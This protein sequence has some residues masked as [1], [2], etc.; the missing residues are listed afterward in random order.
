MFAF[1]NAPMQT[2]RQEGLLI[3]QQE[4][5]MQAT[6]F[7][8]E[9]HMWEDADNL[10]GVCFY[11][12]ELFEQTTIVQMMAHFKA[13]LEQLI[14]NPD[15]R[16]SDLSLFTTAEQRR[17]LLV[18]WNQTK[19]GYQV[20]AC[21]HQLFEQQV[22]HTPDAVAIVC[23]DQ[24]LTY[25]ELNRR[26][27]RLAHHLRRMGVRAEQRVGLLIERG[28][29]MVISMLGILKA[30]GAY[31]PLD[32]Q[33]PPERLSYMLEDAR[34]SVLLT[35]QSLAASFDTRQTRVLNL[36][37]ENDALACENAEN[38]VNELDPFN[39]AYVIYTSGSTGQPKGVAL[40]HRSVVAFL[41]WSRE[42]FT[43][44]ELSGVLA[45]T[46]ICFDLS[47]FEIF[48]PLSVGGKIIV[49]ENALHLPSV[50]ASHEVRLINTVPSVMTE[51]LR[52]GGLPATVRTVNLAGEALSNTLV[53]R[54]YEQPSLRKVWN[55]Y[56]P[57]EDT[58]YS[59]Y[60]LMEKGADRI[61]PIGRPIANT[62][63][64]LLN[65]DLQPVPVGVAGE[66]YLGGAGLARGYLNHPEVTAEKFIPHPF[67]GEVGA[68][69]YKTGDIGRYLPDGNIEY[70]GRIDQQVKVR[71][72][73]IELGE[74]ETVLNQH[75]AV[76][77]AVV[78]AR[79]DARGSNRLVAY[80]AP[81]PNYGGSPEEIDEWRDQRLAQWQALYDE[82]YRQTPPAQDA[83]F[84]IVGWNSN[85]TG[86]PIPAEEMHEWRD[87]LVERILSLR[88]QHVLEIGCGTGLLLFPLAP[89]CT[90]YWAT[91]FSKV[92]LDY[93]RRQLS[94]PELTLSHVKLLHRMADDF[95][96][97]AAQS[98]DV[99]IIN[100]VVQYFPNLDY[101]LRVLKEAVRVVA[102][103]GFI[104]LGDI[105]NLQLLEAF[106]ASV[107]LHRAAPNLK[108]VT[109]LESVRRAATQEEELLIHP[110]FF[111]S[112]REHFPDIN[113]AEVWLKRGRHRNELTCFRYDV[114]LHV[115]TATRTLADFASL[116]WQQEALTLSD[117]RKLLLTR[118]PDLLGIRRVPNARVL[119]AVRAC[120]Q[121]AGAHPP[122]TFKELQKALEKG[123]GVEIEPE[124]VWSLCEDLPYEV[125][126]GWSEAACCFDVIFRRRALSNGESPRLRVAQFSAAAEQAKAPGFYVNDPLHGTFARQFVQELRDLLKRKLPEY[127]IPTAFVMLDAL[128][129]TPN[130]KVN[131]RALPA[132]D[133]SRPELEESYLAP[134]TPVEELLTI[135]WA[136]VLGIER[137]GVRDN[138]FHL[139]GHSLLATQLVSRIRDR[140]AVELTLRTFFATPTIAGLAEK[141]E[142][143]LKGGV[144]LDAPPILPVARQ[145]DLPLSFAQQRLWFLDQLEPHDSA[146][147][148]PVAAHFKGRL[149]L[150]VLH[151]A[152]NEIVGRHE[153][154]RTFFRTIDGEPS[155]SIAPARPVPLPLI[156][157]GELPEAAREIEARQLAL[158]EF[159]Q[160][161]DM[162]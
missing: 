67:G 58:T 130:G 115:G 146:Y 126:I 84:N 22:E 1:Q 61:P 17:Q 26:A 141:I 38:P 27:N 21:L 74:I 136:E 29:E 25:L 85:Y 76:R 63:V 39:L 23:E 99:V 10:W 135:V 81:H 158:E 123:K 37:A 94:Q 104:F 73:R 88:P 118:E 8:V 106:H 40:E 71:G 138:F 5:D 79:A 119:A 102:P 41:N 70:L 44:E 111:T 133:P 144:S 50:L 100:S 129:L 77:E 80:V 162:A 93:V 96:G 108:T 62:Q 19:T 121:L 157:L 82:A 131:R 48:A 160:P 49:V 148:V 75:P 132:P 16:L 14:A 127:M 95:E 36:D 64:Y 122:Q 3:Q 43:E 69:L 113:H 65:H 91:D 18:D 68:R 55:L 159:Q 98:F 120:E 105:R 145:P 83:T 57:S 35:R 125:D 134:R 15:T 152:I 12:T 117:I 156:D 20:N 147:H 89:L 149:D 124:D 87:A 11:S 137:V 90:K 97:M 54:L 52:S 101:L 154:L 33:Y 78:T 139:G 103:G 56:G 30:G 45:S 51:L 142:T 114:L 151:Q 110:A 42:I 161:F 53:Q 140:F 6:R 2:L 34:L 153:V 66:L 60:A 128:P 46:S 13:L 72:Y 109:L 47:V 92:S 150:L 59:T 24:S 116:D 155:Q 112:L 86:Q 7:D 31:V 4:F 107:Q 32:P 143:E 28:I 9:L